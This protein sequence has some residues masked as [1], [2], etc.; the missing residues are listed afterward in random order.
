MSN[1]IKSKTLPIVYSEMSKSLVLGNVSH[2]INPFDIGTMCSEPCVLIIGRE[3][4]GKT[5]ICLDIIKRYYK[6]GNGYIV[7]P[8]EANRQS[9]GDNT[10]V[11]NGVIAYGLNKNKVFDAINSGHYDY[12]V[13]D[14]AVGYKELDVLKDVISTR[15]IAKII[16]LEFPYKL[17]QD[18][19]D[20]VDYVFVS[21]ECNFYSSK[22]IHDSYAKMFP[23]LN[24]FKGFLEDNLRLYDFMVLDNRRSNNND[25]SISEKVSWY[26]RDYVRT[27][28]KLMDEVVDRFKHRLD[29]DTVSI[30]NMDSM[31]SSSDGWEDSDLFISDS[32]VEIEEVLDDG[33][34][35]D[36]DSCDDALNSDLDE[37]TEDEEEEEDVVL[38]TFIHIGISVLII[39]IIMHSLYNFITVLRYIY[40]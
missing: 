36:L 40:S 26:N 10:D 5:S 13:L 31:N 16:T 7:H 12:I 18:I 21:K 33:L 15:G 23:S 22:R 2:D 37:D 11:K 35:S 39:H 29:N 30:E 6:S 17:D 1:H 19:M 38:V 25:D 34:N 3:R 20:M 32:D 8:A 14:N 9:Y 27:C 4:V 24:S 28:I